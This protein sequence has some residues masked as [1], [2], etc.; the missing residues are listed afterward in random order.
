MVIRLHW[1]TTAAS[2]IVMFLNEL[3]LPVNRI[4]GVGDETS[5]DLGNLGITNIRSLITHYPIRWEDRLNAVNISDSLK[6]GYVNTIATVIDHNYIGHNRKK[7][8]KVL[9][10]DK[11]GYLS[12]ICFGRNFLENKLKHGTTIYLYGT[13]IQYKYSEL[14]CSSFEFEEYNPD[15]K[16]A[17]FGI[18]LPI[19]SLSGKL[20][21]NN[22]RKFILSSL[23]NYCR[24]LTN[25]IPENLTNKYSLM[26]KTTSIQ[27]IHF[28]ESIE[29]LNRAQYTLIFEELFHLQITTCRKNLEN[30]RLRNKKTKYS[31][32]LQERL[33]SKLPFKLTTDQ[34]K[35]LEDVMSDL[36]SSRKMN[37]LI[38]GDVG[39]GKTLIALLSSLP[40]IQAGSQVALMAPTELLAKQHS[41]KA[42]ELLHSIG[43]RTAF[44][45]GNLKRKSRDLLL[46]E[47]KNGNID[48]IIGTHALFTNDVK[49]RN[50]ELVIVDEQHRFGVNQRLSLIDKGN[51]CDILLMTATPIPRT[52]T[53]T[54]FGDID[55]STIKTMPKG[56]KTI[57]TH[58]ARVGNEKKVYDFLFNE[59]SKGRQ[60][61]FVYPLIEQ[62]NKVDLKDAESMFNHIKEIF[63]SY[64][65]ALIHS[66]VDEAEKELSMERFNNGEVD[67]LVATSVVEVGVDVPNATVMVIEHAERFGL[68]ALHQLRGRVGRGKHQSYC[69]LIY[70]NIL[71]DDG[72]KRLMIMKETSD[73]FE[74]SKED[75]KLRGPG[76][77]A[78]VKQSGFL[79]FSIANLT[80]D[81]NILETVR[82]E[83]VEILNNDPGLLLPENR[84]LGKLHT[85]APPFSKN[86]ISMG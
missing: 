81:I 49:Y 69:F 34:E 13:N 67:I 37:R 55:V 84:L 45:S 11:S 80:R 12:L 25:E 78:G 7:T 44:L 72:K 57:E 35:A 2:L 4:K 29:N 82:K 66:K 20:T 85:T 46:K 36:N 74:I 83:V 9:I 61:Y 17:K 53:L 14:Q 68:S 56:R 64:E 3:D 33:I 50:L 58:L 21:Q 6:K 24:N 70:S 39:S 26:S 16:P 48:L 76:D 10:Q 47:L 41:E 1:D 65:A 8:L 19:Y 86:F 54:V 52:L 51:D 31:S 77:I 79:K 38:Q 62:S 60:V 5:K 22:L 73:G 71:T 75:L 42:Y 27:N 63:P 32:E 30:K 23:K 40:I 43:V 59:L 18:L 15:V 28:P